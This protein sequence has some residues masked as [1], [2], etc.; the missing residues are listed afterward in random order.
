MTA[1]VATAEPWNTSIGKAGR[2]ALAASW[3]GWMFDGYESYALILVMGVAVRHLLPPEAVPKASVYMGG[4]LAVTLLGWAVGGVAAGV[5]ADYIGRKR[6]LMLSILWY[7]VFTGLSAFSPNY[8]YFLIFRFLTGLGLGAEW[9]PGTAIV[10]EFWPPSSRGRAAG[11]LHAAYGVGS[12]LAS[13]IWLILNPLGSSSWRYMFLI[14]I[15]PAFLLLY[16]RRSVNDAAIWV[17]ANTRRR[18]ARKRLEMGAVSQEDRELTQFTIA[19]VLAD[20]ELRRRV[21]LLMLMSISTAVVWWSVSTWIP[22]YAA[23]LATITGQPSQ[24]WASLAALMFNAGAIAGYLVLG[25]LA[26]TFGRKLTTWLYYLG[27]LLLSVCFFLLVHD[28]HALLVMAAGNGF[29]VGGQFS[30][31]TIYLPELFPTRVRGS[32][33]SLVYDTSRVVAAFGPLL[34]GWLISSFG[35]IRTAAATMSLI[36]VVGLV[37]TPFAGPETKGKPLPA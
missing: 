34:A 11:V 26:D 32:A 31:M 3:L 16:V 27:A 14:G 29:F 2:R 28:T 20:P 10:A 9:G 15:L 12:L 21:G 35:G 30:W 19:R 36:Y 22:E 6:M 23:Q 18:N 17:A 33:I 7:S 13:G 5:L 8:G 25:L 1:T 4:L 24:H 37:V